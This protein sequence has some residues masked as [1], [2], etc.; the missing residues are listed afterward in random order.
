M[1]CIR[2]GGVGY[3]HQRS[4]TIAAKVGLCPVPGWA[5][6]AMA[7]PPQECLLPLSGQ[8]LQQA[9]AKRWRL[10]RAGVRW[11]MRAPGDAFAGIDG[12]FEAWL[13]RPAADL[14]DASGGEGRVEQRA[15]VELAQP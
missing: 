9:S 4:H 11:E 6:R 1:T 13:G 10:S 15:N 12:S 7:P 5:R 3:A 8:N 2:A 14:A